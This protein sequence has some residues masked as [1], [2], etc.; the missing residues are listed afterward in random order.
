[1]VRELTDEADGVG[2]QE[3]Y[4]FV[5]DL[6][7]RGIQGGEELV[8]GEDV[9]FR[10]QIHQGRL[11]HVGIADQRYADHGVATLTAGFGLLVDLLE[12]L[13]QL[14]DLIAD[15]PAVRLDLRLTGTPHA[16]TAPLPFQVGPESAE[17][18]E[19]VLHLRQFHLSFGLGGLGAAGEDVED[20]RG[21]VDDLHLHLLLEDI[22]LLAAE[23]VVEDDHADV[24]VLV[25][26]FRDLVSLTAAHE[27]AVI[28]VV[29]LLHEAFHGLCT[30][31]FRQKFELV[32]VL[33]H[34]LLGLSAHDYADDYGILRLLQ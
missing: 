8:L 16:D 31:G 19:E 27:G 14:G 6:P 11:P 20:E 2:K 30:C 32:Q 23:V 24:F 26:V 13:F 5:G 7:H 34:L 22:D 4:A 3:G 10:Q 1:M 28:G 12:V 9:A 29:E 21:A 33:V 15:D 25:H 17:A 18:G